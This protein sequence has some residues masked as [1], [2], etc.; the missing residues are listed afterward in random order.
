VWPL[1]FT[2]VMH[3][4]VLLGATGVVWAGL[5]AAWCQAQ[6]RLGEAACFFKA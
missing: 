5:N 3:A 4:G 2:L 6:A 1:Q